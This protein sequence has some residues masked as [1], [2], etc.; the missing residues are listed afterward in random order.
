MIT[1]KLHAKYNGYDKNKA[2]KI[3]SNR[4]M[5]PGR[6]D[7]TSKNVLFDQ[8]HTLSGS[9][10]DQSRRARQTTFKGIISI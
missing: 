1:V 10:R 8:R 2:N 3:K 5:V 6:E 4:L 9:L 7:E